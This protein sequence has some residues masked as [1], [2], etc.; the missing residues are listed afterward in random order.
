[1]TLAD[2]NVWLALALSGHQHHTAAA[3]WL[4]KEAAVGSLSF[5]RAT[6]TSFLR[7]LT[8]KAVLNAYGNPPLT[9]EEAWQFSLWVSWISWPPRVTRRVRV[10]M[11][12]SANRITRER[13][14]RSLRTSASTRA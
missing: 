9:N 1:M 4:E 5:C 10:S 14:T 2:S 13:C 7:L 11:A 8:T 3:T 12:R 6:Q